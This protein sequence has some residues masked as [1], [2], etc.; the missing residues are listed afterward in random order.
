[1]EGENR[2]LVID[3]PVEFQKLLIE[4]RHLMENYRSLLWSAFHMVSHEIPKHALYVRGGESNA[5]TL[6]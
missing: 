2:P 6:S 1:M 3:E 4:V 5:K